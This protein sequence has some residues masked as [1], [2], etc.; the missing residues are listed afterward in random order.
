MK[1]DENK[2]SVTKTKRFLPYFIQFNDKYKRTFILSF[3]ELILQML[4]DYIKI[5][6]MHEFVVVIIFNCISSLYS[7]VSF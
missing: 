1:R 4:C 6:Y 7:T 3:R 5:L 2:D